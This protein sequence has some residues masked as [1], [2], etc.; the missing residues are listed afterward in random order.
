[1]TGASV[2]SAYVGDSEATSIWLNLVRSLFIAARAASPAIVFIDEIEALVGK[3]GMGNGGQSDQVQ[4][5][6]LSTL[7]NEMDGIE[8]SNDVLVIGATNRPDL[9]DEALMRPGRFDHVLYVPP[10]NF[11]ERR[12]IFDI[13][14]RKISLDGVDLDQL[15]FFSERYTGADIQNVCREACLIA[16]REN[17]GLA[18]GRRHFEKAFAR[19]SPSI[20]L[21]MLDQYLLFNQSFG[22]KL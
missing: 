13:Y 10:P 19:T 16:I 15:A 22:G 5:R 18:V 20:S 3:R 8:I 21:E 1:M 14:T 12:D 7:L 2:Y 4:E 11:E 17:Q 6:V 9:I